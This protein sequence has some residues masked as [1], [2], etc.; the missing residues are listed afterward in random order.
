M[1]RDT[2]NKCAQNASRRETKQKRKK[3]EGKK[4]REEDK[5]KKTEDRKAPNI[6]NRYTCI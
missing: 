3:G 6:G 5:R 1:K 2:V 4:E